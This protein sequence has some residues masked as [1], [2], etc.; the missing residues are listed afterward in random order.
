MEQSVQRRFEQV[1]VFGSRQYK[2][3][4][5]AVVIDSE[6]ISDTAMQSFAKWTNLS[7][8]TFLLPPSLAKEGEMQADYKVRIFTPFEELPFAGHPTLGSCHV[9]L[10]NLAKDQ[11]NNVIIQECGIGKVKIRRLEDG[12]LAF[13]CP[14]LI[15]SGKVNKED[16]N[17]I[18]KDLNITDTSDIIDIQHADNGPG[19]VLVILKDVQ[20]LLSLKLSHSKY[21]IG[22]AAI[23]TEKES[24]CA[25]EVRTFCPGNNNMTFEDPVT[26]SFNAALAQYFL[27]TG[28]VK[29][30]YEASQGQCIGFEGRLTIFE[31][32]SEIY[33]GGI[34]R[35]CITGQVQL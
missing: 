7:E 19:W 17:Q 3:N 12:K 10:N 9:Y 14:K 15:K 2:G 8:T 4:A 6:G 13:A 35:N 32:E 16:Y 29:L 33:V 22:C 31:E 26:G 34:V 20:T 24:E 18:I 23:Y 30:P 25:V 1:D 27:S 11:E 28:M 21:Y 5:L